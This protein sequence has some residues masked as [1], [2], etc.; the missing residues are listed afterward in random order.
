MAASTIATVIGLAPS[1]I[2]AGNYLGRH[3]GAWAAKP[4]SYRIAKKDAKKAEKE[5]LAIL[6][7][8]KADKNVKDDVIEKAEHYVELCKSIKAFNNNLKDDDLTKG[9]AWDIY[10]ME[11]ARVK[12]ALAIAIKKSSISK[13]TMHK[14][15]ENL[16][17]LINQVELKESDEP[18][19]EDD[20]LTM[21][22]FVI[23]GECEKVVDIAKAINN[24]QQKTE[25][26]EEQ[27]NEEDTTEEETTKSTKTSSQ[28]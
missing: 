28:K 20:Y 26:S 17:V 12:Y 27:D 21:Y 1:L 9:Q 2:Q 22:P 10:V 18:N 6:K 14:L 25:E 15:P 11:I 8:L 19:H 13:K 5:A 4:F 7:V 23:T 24:F 3:I 16:Q